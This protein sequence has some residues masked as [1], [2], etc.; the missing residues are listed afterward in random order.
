MKTVVLATNNQSKV[1][2]LN[3]I[4]T[5]NSSDD[6]K[7]LSLSECGFFGDIEENS[8]TFEGNAY[9]KA[10]TVADFT[11]LATIAD[12]SGLEVDALNGA[13]G[14]YSARYAGEGASSAQLISKLLYEMKDVADGKRNARFTTVMCAVLPNGKVIYERGECHGVIINEARGDGGFGYDPVFYYPPFGKT[15][16]EMKPE[17]KNAISHRAIAA[18]K[19]IE[20]LSALTDDDFNTAKA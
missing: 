18:T 5:A 7:V 13:P 16:A 3:A 14:V 2:E 1:R 15:F 10:K 8:D 12:D 9:I 11:G 6:F 19:L 4:L 17:D 20:K